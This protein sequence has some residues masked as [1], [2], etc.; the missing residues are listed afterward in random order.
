[1]TG[2]KE[3]ACILTRVP[4]LIPALSERG[5]VQALSF[6]QRATNINQVSS[7]GHSGWLRSL[8]FRQQKSHNSQQ[9]CAASLLTD[10]LW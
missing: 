7:G 8:S 2:S 4:S 1:M 9:D 3:H 5:V 6:Q 10:R